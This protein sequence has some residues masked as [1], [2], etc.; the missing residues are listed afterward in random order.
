MAKIATI[1]NQKMNAMKML[2][3]LIVI[4]L[5]AAGCGQLLNR[6]KVKDFVP[7]TYVSSWKTAYSQSRDTIQIDLNASEGSEIFLIVRRTMTEYTGNDKKRPPSYK[8]AKWTGVYVTGSKTITIQNNGRILM[9]DPPKG[10]MAMG[11]TVYKKL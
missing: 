7:G 1:L 10:T 5:L 3:T 2:C 6:D 11:V 8:I 9:F 4:A